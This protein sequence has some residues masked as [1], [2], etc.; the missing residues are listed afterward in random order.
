MSLKTLVYILPDEYL[1]RV[2]ENKPELINWKKIS[3]ESRLSERFIE[4]FKD[5][6]WWEEIFKHQN[7]SDEFKKKYSKMLDS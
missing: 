3:H 1:I 6:V 4:R 2:A 5:K 7:L